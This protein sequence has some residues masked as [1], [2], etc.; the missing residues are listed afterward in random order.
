MRDTYFAARQASIS[1]P[2]PSI[3]RTY[4]A[5]LCRPGAFHWR[6]GVESLAT[7]HRRPA[8]LLVPMNL[9]IK[10][11]LRVRKTVCAYP[12]PTLHLIHLDTSSARAGT[13]VTNTLLVALPAE[14]TN[15]SRSAIATSVMDYDRLH[16]S[17]L[18]HFETRTQMRAFVLCDAQFSQTYIYANCHYGLT[19]GN[20]G[21]EANEGS[22]GA[23]SAVKALYFLAVTYGG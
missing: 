16:A 5:S 7:A 20:S 4:E 11:E 6:G 9:R 17:S 12:C 18:R 3:F 22:V 13:L 2:K 1:A 15:T 14:A 21:E 10:R 19:I 23:A 8:N